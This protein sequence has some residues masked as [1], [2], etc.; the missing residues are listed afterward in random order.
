VLALISA[1]ALLHQQSRRRDHSGA[2][3]ARVE[4]YRAVRRLINDIL[5]EGTQIKVSQSARDTRQAVAEL[6]A[7]GEP[8]SLSQL[9]RKMDLDKSVVSRHVA[10]A[11]R[12]G[13]LH[14]LE[15]R[16]GQPARIVLGD[17][18]GALRNLLPDPELLGGD[19]PRRV[20]ID[21]DGDDEWRGCAGIA[22]VLQS[23]RTTRYH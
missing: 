7:F 18:I 19:K 15:T 8:C 10:S 6:T 3:I 21:S 9:A 5:S 1:H 23:P 2:V 12:R 17:E 4:D 16:K 13:Y 22:M 11:I 20:T 14:N